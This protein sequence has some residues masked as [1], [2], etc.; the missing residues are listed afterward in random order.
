[1]ILCVCPNPS[2]DTRVTVDDFSPAQV[3]RAISEEHFPGGKGTHVALAA[4]ELGEDV[5]LAGFWAGPTGEWIRARCE[6]QGVQCV[7]PQVEGWSRSCLTFQSKGVYNETE[8]LGC[9]PCLEENDVMQLQGA[10]ENLLSRAACLTLSGSWPQGA[11][12][13]GYAGLV[14]LAHEY[15]T[16]VFLDCTGDEFRRALDE[17][18]FA[19]HLNREEAAELLGEREPLKAAQLL[20]QSSTMAVVTA[21]AAGAYFVQDGEAIH[22]RC[23]IDEVQSAVGAGDCL[24]AGLAVAKARGFSFEGAARLAT[25]CGAANCL[26]PELGMLQRADV[27]SLLKSAV[28]KSP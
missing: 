18:P 22:A 19:V 9:G 3:H 1:M 24:L 10:I 20:A 28:I 26:R 6:E 4:R 11:P 17:K 27:E 15:S 16:P 2:V 23:E 25:A 5:V 8:L 7:G 12:R 14:R 21:G 13:G